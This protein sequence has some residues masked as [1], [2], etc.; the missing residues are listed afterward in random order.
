[1]G[2]YPAVIGGGGKQFGPGARGKTSFFVISPCASNSSSAVQASMAINELTNDLFIFGGYGQDFNGRWGYLN[3]LWRYNLNSNTFFWLGGSSSVAAGPSTTNQPCGRSAA[4]MFA[5]Q[6]GL[7]FALT[8]FGGVGNPAGAAAGALDDA[9]TINTQ[10]APGYTQAAPPSSR[11]FSTTT[12]AAPVTAQHTT[13]EG[14]VTHAP[15]TT[16]AP[17]TV[18]GTTAAPTSAHAPTSVHATTAHAAAQPTTSKKP[19]VETD[20]PKPTPPPTPAIEPATKATVAPTRAPLFD[21]TSPQKIAA[22]VM[23]SF[24]AIVLLVGGIIFLGFA[25]T[26]AAPAGSR[27]VS[28]PYLAV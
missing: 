23:G 3:D 21:A 25:M 24:I 4:A 7:Q 11:T 6:D 14:A 17:L 26:S 27:I 22:L 18:G 10:I 2:N 1:M 20:E 9:W 13:E 16:K 19:V 8:I 28:E 12:S 5:G 15:T